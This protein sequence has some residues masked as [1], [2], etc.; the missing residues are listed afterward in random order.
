MTASEMTASETTASAS[1][2]TA[3]AMTASETTA[4]ASEMTASAM[5]RIRELR[6]ACDDSAV[7]RRCSVLQVFMKEE[8][9][10][11]KPCLGFMPGVCASVA[12]KNRR[13]SHLDGRSCNFFVEQEFEQ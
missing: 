8:K 12:V 3:S 4:S 10:R 11:P 6:K 5:T 9:K 7:C 1:E 13:Q 2:M